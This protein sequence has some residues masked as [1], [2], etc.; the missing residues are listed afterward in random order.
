MGGVLQGVERLR[1][2][3]GLLLRFP[4]RQEQLASLCLVG[5]FL[6]CP[7]LQGHLIEPYRF[8]ISRQR[9]VAITRAHRIGH[10]FVNVTVL[11]RFHQVMR[12]RS[13]IFL[14]PIRKQ[15]LQRLRHSV[16]PCAAPGGQ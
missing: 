4:E 15:R 5:L 3:A 1:M 13:V 12:Q 2:H 7:C 10:G 6:T 14:Q 9:H 11:T 16:V 8:G